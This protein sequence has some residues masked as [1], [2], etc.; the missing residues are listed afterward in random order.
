[1]KDPI[2]IV[3]AAVISVT[4]L[5]ATP[6]FAQYA[7]VTAPNVTRA[8][9]LR[10]VQEL[11]ALGYEPSREGKYPADLQTALQQLAKTHQGNTGAALVSQAP[12]R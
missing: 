12:S 8:D 1:M 4:A 9:L 3:C 2:R 7:Q 6:V 5:I 10:E 11:A